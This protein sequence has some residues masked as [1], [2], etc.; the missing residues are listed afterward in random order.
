MNRE[1]AIQEAV[2][3]MIRY[4]NPERVYLFGSA[5]RGDA[6]PSSDVDFLVVLPDS[7]PKEHLFGGVYRQLAGLTVPI[8]VVAMRRRDFEARKDWLM[9]LPAIAL[10]EGK[11]LYDARPQAA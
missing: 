1:Q 2:R 11:L 6:R 4:F 8:D 3:R 9:S 7:A 5:A 10:R